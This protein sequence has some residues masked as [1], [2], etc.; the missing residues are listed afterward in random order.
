MSTPFNSP[1]NTHSNSPSNP[2][3]EDYTFYIIVG[4]SITVT[5]AW[6]G[7]SYVTKRN[8]G[9]ISGGSSEYPP[10]GGFY[11]YYPYL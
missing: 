5:L 6:L 8:L 10:S 9:L 4:I 11:I 1:S 7:L 3:K 2:K